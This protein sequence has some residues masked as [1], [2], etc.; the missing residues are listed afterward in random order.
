MEV[1]ILDMAATAQA[2]LAIIPSE[3]ITIPTEDTR[4]MGGN[5]SI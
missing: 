3:A 4:I 2:R 1:S 5:F